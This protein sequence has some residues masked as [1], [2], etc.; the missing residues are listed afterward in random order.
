MCLAK[1]KKSA[2]FIIQFIFATIHGSHYTISANFYLYLQYFQQKVF[3]FSKISKSQT[4]PQWCLSL[5]CASQGEFNGRWH[6]SSKGNWLPVIL[7]STVIGGRSSSPQQPTSIIIEVRA[8]V[9]MTPKGFILSIKSLH[10]YSCLW[11]GFTFIKMI[12][13]GFWFSDWARIHPPYIY[14][15]IGK[16]KK[17]K[18]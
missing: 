1:I 6:L 18:Y 14:I 13:L 3:S 12:L 11:A 4:N 8:F 7:L 15:Y 17:K 9:E 5:F 10:P 16:E 2:Y